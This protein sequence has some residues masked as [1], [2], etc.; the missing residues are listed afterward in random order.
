M[1]R[2]IGL[3]DSGLGGFSIYYGLKQHFPDAPLIMLADQKNAP[4]GP[5]S[6][7]QLHEITVIN[8]DLLIKMGCNHILFACNTISALLL[9]SMQRLFPDIEIVGVIDATVA[10]VDPVDSLA[11]IATKANIESHAY[12]SKLKDKFP[13]IKIKEII[14]HDLATMIEDLVDEQHI[15]S[16]IDMLLEGIDVDVMILGCTHY[17]L[18]RHLFEKQKSIILIDSIDAMVKELTPWLKD[19]TGPSLIMTTSDPTTLKK[20]L[21][22]IFDKEED[23][24]KAGD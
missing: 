14:A 4:Y 18:V 1:T 15:G 2:P 8:I 10:T 19:N 23:V 24:I 6:F 5:K 9:D 3:I 7:Q 21:K 13:S 20:Q 22:T 11:V 16:Y 17:P 12:Q